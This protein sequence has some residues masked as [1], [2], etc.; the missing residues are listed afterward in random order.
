MSHKRG[1]EA[2]ELGRRFGRNLVEFRG[3]AGLSQVATAERAGLRRTEVGLIEAGER[4]P[5]LDAIVRLAG[6]LEVQPCA[7]LTGMAW[8]LEPPKEGSK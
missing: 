4:L 8:N 1:P 3:R 6:A 7:L 5:R 2:A